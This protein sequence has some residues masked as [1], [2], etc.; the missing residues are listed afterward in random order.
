MRHGVSYDVHDGVTLE[1]KLE[2]PIYIADGLNDVSKRDNWNDSAPDEY[3]LPTESWREHVARR[4]RYEDIQAILANGGVKSINDLITY[5]LD[6]EKF[7][8][9][10]IGYSEGP[11]LVRAFWKSVAN[12]SVLDPT[13]G[14]GAFLFAA[15]NILEPVYSAC[16]DAMRQFLE[17]QTTSK[18]KHHPES[19]NDFRDI[20]EQVAS[21][22]NETYFILKSIIVNNLYGVDIME[23]AVE[24]CKLRLFLKLVSKL[25]TVEQVEPLPDIDFNIRSGNALVGFA[26]LD[27]VQKA[28]GSKF[29]YA[30]YIPKIAEQAGVAGKAFLKFQSIQTEHALD[31][32]ASAQAKSML[33][34]CLDELRMEL[35]GY[36]ANEYNVDSEDQTAY[37]QW[38]K[39]HRPFHWFVEFYGIM[40]AG[41]FDVTIG[42]P[43]YVEYRTISKYWSIKGYATETCGNLYAFV[44][45][46]NTILT[47]TRGRSG[48]IV[49]HSA[50]CTDRMA[51][52]MRLLFENNT[53]W[54]STYDIRPS[55]LFA[56]VDQ[57]L[58]IYLTDVHETSSKMYSSRYLRWHESFRPFLLLTLQY[59]NAK[60]VIDS[61]SAPKVQ[62]HME[63]KLLA[64]LYHHSPVSYRLSR[65]ARS[66][67]YFHNGPRYWIRF[68]DF[69]PYFWNERDGE[70]ASSHVKELT[71]DTKPNA[72]ATVA[73][74]NSSLFYWWFLIMS[75]CRDLNLREI[76]TF[77][78]G[79]DRMPQ[80]LKARLA[81]LT[82]QLMTNFNKH[83]TR[84]ETRYQTTGKVI[85]D[86]FNQKPSK[87]IVDEIDRVLAEHYGFT[88][89]E[90]DFIINYD[91]K[92]RMGL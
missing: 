65:T 21:H 88:E 79:L 2:L 45:E 4:G 31:A 10:V 16:L 77:P 13:C 14:S 69:V 52:V 30:N 38:R 73:A 59:V 6:I 44:T 62:S 35:N 70:Q 3:A 89:E 26:S 19:L 90:L 34:K 39:S 82:D 17:D 12:V 64:K 36:L 20:L 51:K 84:K 72:A 23:E 42:N 60:V 48:M 56:G 47:A 83:K 49:P 71:L 25:E 29:D 22:E 78:L 74:L 81:T 33:R 58:A 28:L 91:I 9:D 8:Q 27:E 46:R 80:A 67:I 75:D 53:T 24:I 7:T 15:L 32:S 43:P 37:Q 61:N 11:E 68:M 66:T 5:N 87:P 1:G 92:F 50:I 41:G 40:Q 76:E 18:R 54:V 85:Y 55:K 86:E 57:R 63:T